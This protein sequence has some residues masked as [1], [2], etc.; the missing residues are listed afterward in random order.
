MH[1]LSQSL[2]CW[3]ASL[4]WRT[5]V[6]Y[7]VLA[8]VYDAL[9]GDRLFTQLRRVFDWLVQCYGIHFSS[10]ADVACGTG[11]FAADHPRRQRQPQRI[12]DREA[13]LQRWQVRP[14]IKAR[15]RTETVHLEQLLHALRTQLTTA[16]KSGKIVL[17]F[18]YF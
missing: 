13:N 12:H 1:P 7:A 8:P 2:N 5:A 18:L 3:M 17:N 16:L 10:A 4:G 14:M 6:S 11:T 15:G 9:L